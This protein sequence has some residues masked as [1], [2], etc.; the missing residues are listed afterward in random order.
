MIEL[1]QKKTPENFFHLSCG[2]KFA[3]F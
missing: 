2:R 3:R 1:L